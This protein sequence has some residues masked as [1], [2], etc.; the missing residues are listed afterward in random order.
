MHK[1]MA[2]HVHQVKII[3]TPIIFANT[4]IRK[5]SS[6]AGV[7]GAWYVLYLEMGDVELLL[8]HVQGNKSSCGL[9]RPSHPSLP[10]GHAKMLQLGPRSPDAQL[11][12]LR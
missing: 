5:V 2:V 8:R 1:G 9:F 7:S 4:K 10:F 3:E 12:G 11:T 6:T